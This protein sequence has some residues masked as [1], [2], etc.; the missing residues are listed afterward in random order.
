VSH[1]AAPACL[2]PEE[3]EL[4]A[5]DEPV[6]DAIRAH[7]VECTSCRAAVG[8]SRLNQHFLRELLADWA[9]DDG[10]RTQ[11]TAQSTSE[12]EQESG[13]APTPDADR[14]QRSALRDYR[15]LHE[16]HRGAQGVVHRA[17]HI[18]TGRPAAVKIMHVGSLRRRVRMQREASL[19]AAL[20]HPGIV[21]LHDCGELPDGGYAI[22]MELV[23]GE[24][25]DA[26]GRRIRSANAPQHEVI[27]RIVSVIAFACDAVQHAH[28]RGVIHRDIKPSNILVDTDDRPHVLDFG[29][30]RRAADADSTDRVT[31]TGEIAC[32]LA[33]AAPEQVNDSASH[34]DTRSDIYSLGVVLYELL[35]GQLPYPTDRSVADAIGNILH[36]AAPPLRARES[37]V[38]EDLETIVQKALAKEP[39]RRYQSA[40]ALRADLL[41]WLAYEAIDARR[42]SRLYM[43]RKSLRR[44]RGP[45]AV[46]AAVT[47]ALVG[48]AVVAGISAAR[49]AAARDLAAI[50]QRRA[51]DEA[52]RWEA[53]AAVLHE[54][55]PAVD[56]TFQEYAFGPMHKAVLGLSDRLSAGLF[57][58]DPGAQA[59]IHTA[60]G[61][62]CAGRGSPRLAEV[63]FRE[64]LR[65]VAM[66]P[67]AGPEQVAAAQARLAD[68][69]VSRNGID[70]A[71]R[72]ATAALATLRASGSAGA[73]ALP[74]ALRT[75]AQVALA[76]NAP[77]R[78]ESL[79][80]EALALSEDK[81]NRM[82][83]EAAPIRQTLARV[84]RARG[85]WIEA[86]REATQG[87]A[88]TFV[89]VSDFD[90]HVAEAI[91]TLALC[92]A[93]HQPA[94]SR[95]LSG[96]ARSIRT[97][98][99]DAGT[100]D[101]L[102]QLKT[103]LL[104]ANHPDIVETLASRV[105][106]WRDQGASTETCRA[107][108]A[109]LPRARQLMGE[110]AMVVADILEAQYT[111]A[112]LDRDFDTVLRAMDEFLAIMR[113][114]LPGK[115][116]VHLAVVLREC[117]SH[118]SAMKR[119][120]VADAYWNETIDWVE[121]R[122]G[123]VHRELAWAL[124][125]HANYR[126]WHQGASLAPLVEIDRAIDM[127]QR[128]D[129][130]PSYHLASMHVMR[131]AF[132]S[133]LG[134]A[135][136]CACSLARAVEICDASPEAETHRSVYFDLIYEP[137]TLS[138]DP[139]CCDL[140][141]QLKNGTRDVEAVA[142]GGER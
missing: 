127:L 59:A 58:E 125:L 54:L 48:G 5:A 42:D 69:L 135:D 102:L 12:Q 87:L 51:R 99:S 115:D 9:P 19:A 130:R 74:A 136:E 57:A 89:A 40:S 68:F 79:C 113:R 23:D 73:P 123:P 32:T 30:A 20:R 120:D 88:R 36:T 67:D 15:L 16:L 114:I 11:R 13:P 33:Y 82:A 65:V 62:V 81:D 97:G 78:A 46:V 118:A 90:P 105:R 8:E 18:P 22:A 53:V 83:R 70:E 1:P 91:E 26:W 44:H 66:Q 107:A 52:R 80:R 101:R 37:L 39:V 96:V 141:W 76:K 64:A 138:G 100:F 24:M 119:F 133:T 126:F 93:E 140:L 108:E 106:Y 112:Y 17:V 47:L 85:N 92:I 84:L 137:I 3:I 116:D 124:G 117:A 7:A 132:L 34:V 75:M 109:A 45:V 25:L 72:L 38:D 14:R 21:T 134:E 131:A 110:N 95:E 122:L 6:T 121:S 86:Q 10:A 43:F 63:Q 49:S 2:S 27:R 104:G 128:I 139:R 129:P 55:I 71:D 41:H 61:E 4:V 111:S 56:P 35:T 50:E 142:A 98:A 94:E 60:L 28:T 31:L 77:D 29:I 103:E